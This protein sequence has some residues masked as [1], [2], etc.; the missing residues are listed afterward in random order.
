MCPESNSYILDS[1]LLKLMIYYP[2]KQSFLSV[3]FIV[4]LSVDHTVYKF[5]RTYKVEKLHLVVFFL[6]ISSINIEGNNVSWTV[7][8]EVNGQIE[9]ECELVPSSGEH[10]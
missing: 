7:S 8:R 1:F 10:R 9:E 3:L 4:F 2:L 5:Q 6:L